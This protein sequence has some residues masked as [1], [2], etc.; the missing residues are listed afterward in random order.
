MRVYPETGT[1]HSTLLTNRNSNHLL[2][3]I[4]IINF[5]C[6]TNLSFLFE[7]RTMSAAYHSDGRGYRSSGRSLA[8]FHACLTTEIAFVTLAQHNYNK[9]IKIKVFK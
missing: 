3:L 4:D 2:L 6:S 1:T 9:V 5:S 7:M 8:N